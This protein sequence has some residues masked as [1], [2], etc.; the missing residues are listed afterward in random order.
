MGTANA[1][2]TLVHDL[3]LSLD[4]SS[5]TRVLSLNFSS[6]FDFES[7]GTLYKL[8]VAGGGHPVFNVLKNLSNRSQR[9][10]VD[11]SFSHVKPVL[12]EVP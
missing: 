5:E 12:S 4:S 1:L 2:L 6:D 10:S 7:R 9:V 3:Q 11:G 8:K